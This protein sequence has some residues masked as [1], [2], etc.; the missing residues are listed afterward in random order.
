[1]FKREKKPVLT[2]LL[3][4]THLRESDRLSRLVS[5]LAVAFTWAVATSE[6]T[7]EKER[8]QG[9]LPRVKRHSGR[10]VS[11]F[12]RGLDIL[13]NLLAPLAGNYDKANLL[14]VTRILYAI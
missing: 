4:A 13:R 7:E 1:M 11:T 2:D 12:R 3:E 10:A 6:A 8:Q 5:V 14:N 9:E